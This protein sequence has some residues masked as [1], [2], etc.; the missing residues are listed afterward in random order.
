MEIGHPW[1]GAA[2]TNFLRRFPSPRHVQNL[3]LTFLI[4][5]PRS[6]NLPSLTVGS[7]IFMLHLQGC[8]ITK[9]TSKVFAIR[10][11]DLEG[12]LRSCKSEIS[13]F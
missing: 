9:A 4:Q 13:M 10:Q 2:S 8:A 12:C 5:L 6:R 3:V 1:T 7:L 11:H